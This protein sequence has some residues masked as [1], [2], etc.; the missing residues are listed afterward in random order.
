VPGQVMVANGLKAGDRIVTDGVNK[1]KP[2]AK[3][4]A[5]AAAAG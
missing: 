1:L 4:K 3:V 2:G 5:V